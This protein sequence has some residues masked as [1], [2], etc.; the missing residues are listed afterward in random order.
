MSKRKQ[1]PGHLTP[2]QREA[3]FS[4]LT[5][6]GCIVCA[7]LQRGWVEPE[8][9]HLKGYPW[10]GTGQRATDS[11]TIPLC[12]AHHRHGPAGYHHS[13]A[14]FAESFGAQAALLDAANEVIEFGGALPW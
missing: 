6:M 4:A 11:Y 2:S 14:E 7:R 3:R 1:R 8:I 9:H 5:R 10:S 13:P 12:P